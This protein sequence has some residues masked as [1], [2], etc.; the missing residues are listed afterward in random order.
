MKALSYVLAVLAG[1][2]LAVLVL[3]LGPA[4]G[5]KNELSPAQTKEV[6]A[7]LQQYLN[8]HPEVVGHA[9]EQLQQREKTAAREAQR[10]L[11]KANAAAILHED[12]DPVLG[13]PQ[14][15]VTIVEFFDYRCPYCK[16][17]FPSVMES[18]RDDGHIRLV[19][20]EFPI[21]GA[22]SQTAT[23]AALA[24]I[25]QGK[26]EAFH[27]ALL[28]AKSELTQDTILEI[29]KSVGLDVKRLTD[30]MTKPEV[31]A[32]IKR[33]YELAAILKID[34][35]PTFVIG[36]QLI[37]GAIDKAAIE[38]LVREARDNSKS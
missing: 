31:D 1:A 2:A 33:N 9:I 29:A 30:D 8:A 13:N 4:W 11:V 35:T 32:A 7:V 22:A 37:P 27:M 6:E 38:R 20:K 15:D 12:A 17:T 25:K 14:G 10:S 24:S 3:V 34:G 26:Y 21:L 23:R 19:L 28:G 5:G 16:R 18:L 36:E